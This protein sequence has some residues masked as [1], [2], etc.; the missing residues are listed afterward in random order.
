MSNL[1]IKII[2]STLYLTVNIVA[3]D[4]TVAAYNV[5]NLFD[6]NKDGTEY[7]RYIPNTHDWN[8]LTFDIKLENISNVI[9]A[10]NAD[11]IVLNE[12]E[13][14]N[15]LAAL[16]KR[17]FLKMAPYKYWILGDKPNLSS[18][19]SAILSKYPIINSK[20][21][22]IPKKDKFYTRNI[23]EADILVNNDTLKV[24]ALH[25]PS[26]RHKESSRIR[27][28]N[29]LLKRIKQLSPKTDYL[30]IGDLNSN[31]NEAETFYTTNHDNVNSKTAI[32]HILGTAIS[33]PGENLCF[34]NPIKKNSEKKNNHYN[35]WI[36]VAETKRFSYIYNGNYNTLD[37]IIMSPALFDNKGISYRQYS[38]S[39]FTWNNKL[40]NEKG[41]NKW[42]FI[43]N[44]NG[45]FHEGKGYSD[46]L[47]II[48]S[49]T[50]DKA[51]FSKS[52][53]NCY[54]YLSD[55]ILCGFETGVEGW[56]CTNSNFRILRNSNF[57]RSGNKSLQ[58]KGLSKRNASVAKITFNNLLYNFEKLTFFL[59]GSGKIAIQI[60][61]NSSQKF[62]LNINK[63]N[64]LNKRASYHTLSLSE[65]QKITVPI[66]KTLV[67]SERLTLAIK[68][69]KN[70]LLNLNID[71]IKGN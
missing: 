49:F 71:D 23:L 1:K 66:P 53:I 5:Q 50:T 22:G 59:K 65:W 13:N 30:L 16:R 56:I 41:I 37:H 44:Q 2:I 10:L 18:V 26:K 46:H 12:I 6:L 34:Y 64:K 43:H 69:Y 36:E 9:K 17:L 42:S 48:A 62:Y 57:Q 28:A 35:P 47:P 31:Y 67:N 60:S 55:K 40:I 39:H 3:I 19:N 25:W 7:E 68:S 11:I 14:K 20:T 52:S 32:N 58:I 61:K 27:V 63:K 38:F 21:I 29:Q 15:A 8:N 4:F 45:S 54:E 51:K 33:S 70:S 24:F